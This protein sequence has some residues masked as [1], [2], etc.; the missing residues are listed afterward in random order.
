MAE[1]GKNLIGYGAAQVFDTSRSTN[2]YAKLLQKKEKDALAADEKF[3]K[4]LSIDS[5]GL[6]AVDIPGY[7]KK[8]NEFVEWSANNQVDLKNPTK[9]PLV[10][11][12]YQKR[13]NELLQD[14][15]RSSQA[16]QKQIDS[17]KTLINGREEFYNILNVDAINNLSETDIYSDNFDEVLNFNLK[18]DVNKALSKIPV[19]DL[20]QE[21]IFESEKGVKTTRYAVKEDALENTVNNFFNQYSIEFLSD[22]GSEDLA[23]DFIRQN[24]RSRIKS[25]K[26]TTRE[27]SGGGLNIGFGGG[28]TGKVNYDVVNL[29]GEAAGAKYS[30]FGFQNAR[31]ISFGFIKGENRPITFTSKDGKQTFEDVIP[32][33]IIVDPETGNQGFVFYKPGKKLSDSERRDIIA[34]KVS[35]LKADTSLKISDEEAN[36][37]AREYADALETGAEFSASDVP[38]GQIN[39]HYDNLYDKLEEGGLFKATKKEKI[40]NNDPLGL[41]L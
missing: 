34:D 16:K 36:A 4:S 14:V 19:G 35:E 30:D 29:S 40:N 25:D 37:Q 20:S 23:K 6:R 21:S 8:Y 13:K 9:N 15:S 38:I 5:K 22:F 10:F 11:Q 2:M 41:G 26:A 17:S 31:E 1:L 18:R 7:T 28:S 12:E 24:V 39:V 33:A 27:G 32:K 3:L